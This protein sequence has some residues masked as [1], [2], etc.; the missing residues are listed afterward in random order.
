MVL[1]SSEHKDGVAHLETSTLD[2]EKHLKPR[3]ALHETLTATK[4]EL[5]PEEEIKALKASKKYLHS[6]KNIKVQ[7][8]AQISV[9]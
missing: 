9:Q 2:G 8:E 1:I 7:L 6:I 5:L 4:I 3:T